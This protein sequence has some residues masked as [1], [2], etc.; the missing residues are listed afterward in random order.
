[1]LREDGKVKEIWG[2]QFRIVKNG[3][4]EAEVFAFVGRLIEQN[5][6]L[7][8]KLEHV[9]SLKKLA[10]NAVIEATK[11]AKRMKTETRQEA[12]EKAR[13]II[14]QAEEK[15]K[16]E[17]ER[18]IA[19]AEKSSLDRI[20][21][22]EQLA[23]DVLQAAEEKAKEH[24]EQIIA[25]AEQ[26][27]REQAEQIIA[28]VEQN[29]REQAE[30]ETKAEA[31]RIVAK[32]EKS[33]LDRIAAAEEKARA[34]AEE[35]SQEKLSLAEQEAKD[36]IKAAEEKA[37]EI[38]RLGEE[39]ASRIVT[40]ARRR[41][42]EEAALIGQEAGQRLPASGIIAESAIEEVARR[43]LEELLS[44]SEERKATQPSKTKA[45]V[46]APADTVSAEMR[47]QTSLGKEAAAEKES[48]ALY[49]GTVE[50]AILP[51]VATN[52]LL[53]LHRQLTKAR[54]VKVMDVAGSAGKG[55][56]IKLFL[57]S[58]TRLIDMLENMPEV[59]EATAATK[60][61]RNTGAPQ[62]RPGKPAVR[63]IE[64][65]IRK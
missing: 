65:T 3:L 59:R 63:R 40:E 26:N 38:K 57:K 37:E 17:A 39:E 9:D 10:E 30:Y 16:A 2:R 28:R 64:V 56:I 14:I 19:E 27:A 29:A 13:E 47:E 1:M 41:V 62:H 60:Q 49:S 25:K 46:P 36:M 7:S 4:D 18:I 51:P 33:S 53:R 20:A 61:S 31:E 45:A 34:Q 58:P 15:T 54:Q 52:K 48:P 32:A 42:E 8:S 6:E 23:Q 11:Q 44:N 22:A 55:V 35:L 21:S 50:L 12:S 5:R 43:V 24:A